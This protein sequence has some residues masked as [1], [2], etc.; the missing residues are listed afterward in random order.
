VARIPVIA[1]ALAALIAGCGG[2]VAKKAGDRPETRAQQVRQSG[3]EEGDGAAA[4]ARIPASD[5][6]AFFQMS[7]AIGVLSSHAAVVVVAQ[8]RRAGEIRALVVLHRRVAALRPA[9][10]QLASLRVQLLAAIDAAR[11]GRL[12]SRSARA[13]LTV[14]EAMVRSLR[15]YARSHPAV[16]GLVP[17]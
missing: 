4:L 15:L 11:R 1:A 12:A 13:A 6:T 3:N 9:D 8:V 17:E 5:R 2:Q 10:S 14:T 7:S 16:A